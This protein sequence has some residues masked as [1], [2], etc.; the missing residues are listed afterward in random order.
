MQQMVCTDIAWLS[1]PYPLRRRIPGN[2]ENVDALDTNVA[3][4]SELF[5]VSD[6]GVLCLLPVSMKQW[7]ANLLV[8][9]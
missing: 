7:Q 6:S 9:K 1:L 4:S 2:E 5:F 8:C 3:M